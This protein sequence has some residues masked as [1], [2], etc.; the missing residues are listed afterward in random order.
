MTATRQTGFT[1]IE[2]LIALA[3]VSVALA[4]FVRVTSQTATNMTHIEQQT[5][6]MLS[7]QNSLNE[8]RMTPLPP[9]GIHQAECPQGDLEFICRLQV[10]PLQQGMR[11][12]S[13]D[14]YLSQNSDR[15]L[16]SLQTW[17]PEAQ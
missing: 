1:L 3:I 5:L 15:Q 17:L 9:S 8:V 11:S 7:A 12:V 14:V 2:V 16:A 10:G 4:A 13:I 6:A